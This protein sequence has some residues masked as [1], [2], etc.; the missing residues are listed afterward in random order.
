MP[1]N[2]VLP[3]RLVLLFAA[4]VLGAFA[5]ACGDDEPGATPTAAPSETAAPTATATPAP[6]ETPRPPPNARPFPPEL[7]AQ[8]QPVLDR[9]AELRGTPPKGEVAMNLVGR[10]EA[11]EYFRNDFTEEDLRRFQVQEDV[12]HLLSMIPE[13]TDLLDTFLGFLGQGVLGFYDTDLKAFY[14]LDDLGGLDTFVARSTL[15]HE[16]THALQ[17]QYYGL[18]ALGESREEDWDASLALAQTVEG[19]AVATETAFAGFS[20][21][22]VTC[23][24]IPP[25]GGGGTP[26]V[27]RRDL[28]TWYEDGL[29]FVQAVR[30]RLANGATAIF[31]RLPATTEQVLH[32]DKYLAGEGAVA[33]TLPALEGALG[34]G[35]GEIDGSTLGEYTLQ[36][37]L[38]LGMTAERPRVQEAAAGWGGDAWRLYGREE[39]RL[40]AATVAWDSAADAQQ[41]WLA[42]A[43]SVRARAASFEGAEGSL[44]AVMN[45]KTWRA[46]LSG[47]PASPAGRRVTF[48]VSGDAAAAERA[49]GALALP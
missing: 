44:R 27:V 9:V 7:R 25:V 38:V 11:T 24:S 35:W 2:R 28:M 43:D 37:L 21:R 23:F 34:E 22:L 31:E 36:N 17:D 39:A 15:V 40:F 29:C 3:A 41:F 42:L 13:S 14:L 26:Y 20:V 32:P 1:S 12:Y 30:E 19:E 18:K 8:V 33:V 10:R 48:V 4:L 16:F 5:L 49:A 45:G 46:A 47:D 6:A